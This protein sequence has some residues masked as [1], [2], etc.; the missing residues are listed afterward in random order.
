M[1]C[2]YRYD[3]NRNGVDKRGQSSGTHRPMLTRERRVSTNGSGVP[4]LN[5]AY[6]HATTPINPHE[7]KGVEVTVSE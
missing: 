3:F 1:R 5:H 7:F 6:V 4:V 2:G